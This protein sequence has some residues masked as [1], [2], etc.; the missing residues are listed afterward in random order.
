ME[1]TNTFLDDFVEL[2]YPNKYSSK[3]EDNNFRN[4]VLIK[5]NVI[6]RS[7]NILLGLYILEDHKHK[8]FIDLVD[9]I[10]SELDYL[11][12][13]KMLK[14]LTLLDNKIISSLYTVNNFRRAQAHFKF[15]DLLI[16]ANDQN[17][18]KFKQDSIKALRG[19]FKK[20]LTFDYNFK[21]ELKKIV[22]EENSK[23]RLD[24]LKEGINRK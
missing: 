9:K 12:K 11:K 4:Y 23:K 10:Y 7:I 21:R 24:R 14:D 3:P 19:L 18:N 20:I 6:E 17:F 15:D 13:V 8:H 2:I 5:H 1:K 22:A 16:K